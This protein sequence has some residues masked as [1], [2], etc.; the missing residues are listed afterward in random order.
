M[1]LPAEIYSSDSVRRIDQNAIGEARIDAYALMARAARAALELAL[2]TFGNAR[3][4]QVVCGGGNNG[5]DGYVLA[6]LA[7]EQGID[8]TALALVPPRSLRGDAARACRDFI[9]AGGS[10][11]GWRGELDANAELLVDA[12]L[13]SGLRRELEGPFA[14]AVDAICRHGAPVLALDIPSGLSGDTGEVLGRAV[15]ADRTITFV[16]LKSGL[17]LADAPDFVGELSFAGLD[18][19]ADC[20]ASIVPD[21]RRIDEGAISRALAPR[22]RS[23]HKGDFG[24]LLLV[25]GGPGMA[26]AI[27]LTGEAALRAG[28]GRVSIATLPAHCAAIASG[29]PEL[30]CHGVGNV[31]DL[32]RLLERA[33]TLAIGP[34]LGTDT[35][36]RE[37]FDAVLASGLPAVV[38][39]DALNL[40]AERRERRDNW[41]LTP[42]PGEAGR[43]LGCPAREIQADRRRALDDLMRRYGGV[44]VLKG[45]G[46]LVSAAAGPP[47]LCTAGN[48]G[49]AAPG[50][51]DV[52][53]GV[54]GALLAQGCT[55]EDASVAGVE[56]HARAG[57]AAAAQ[58]PRGLIASDLLPALR[59]WV[60]P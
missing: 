49:M 50:M 14:E 30:M 19:P 39:A 32:R 40:L 16:G 31:P 48:P 24:H 8:V 1:N 6:R 22:R 51:G 41:I 13:G 28:A 44:I 4:W 60:N 58:A 52:L 36:A 11:Q 34:G 21:M 42:H 29:R 20:R 9:A 56:A 43:L 33:T 47:W 3:R 10:V 53:T 18:I 12:I 23:A 57:D 15:S 59:A 38:D 45:A 26:G 37:L 7:A 35:W 17:F 25:G 46:T 27:R 2:Q 55:F 54:I 5:G